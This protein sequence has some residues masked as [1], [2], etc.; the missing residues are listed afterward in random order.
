MPA[1]EDS[2]KTGLPRSHGDTVIV[3]TLTGKGVRIEFVKGSR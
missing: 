1:S 3:Y 2:A